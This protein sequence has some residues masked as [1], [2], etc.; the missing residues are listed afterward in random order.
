MIRALHACIHT[1]I[2]TYAQINV[3]KA[4]LDRSQDDEGPDDDSDSFKISTREH[5]SDQGEGDSEGNSQVAGGAEEG[6][7]QEEEVVYMYVCMCVCVC[8][9]VCVCVCMHVCMWRMEVVR[10]T[11]RKLLGRLKMKMRAYR[12]RRWC[13]CMH[14]CVFVFKYI[15]M[16]THI[17][18]YICR[19]T[20]RQQRSGR[21]C[22]KRRIRAMNATF[23]TI[24]S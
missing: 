22:S 3:I 21:E 7:I 19:K 5:K 11:T 16:H 9:F 18:T 12:R 6:S 1:F 15:H 14:A 8:V 10:G 20:R 2:Q 4:D 24:R 17:H 13:M 23:L